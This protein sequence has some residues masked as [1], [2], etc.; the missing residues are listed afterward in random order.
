MELGHNRVLELLGL[1]GSGRIC[2]TIRP[3]VVSNWAECAAGLALVVEKSELRPKVFWTR[4]REW[5]RLEHL[6]Y[7]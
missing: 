5:L 7:L 4:V 3:G 2:W 1:Q 6:G